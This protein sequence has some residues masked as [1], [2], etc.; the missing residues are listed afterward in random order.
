MKNTVV[1]LILISPLFSQS[2]LIKPKVQPLYDE[3]YEIE[4][5]NN[6]LGSASVSYSYNWDTSLEIDGNYNIK[7]V[8]N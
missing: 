5:W 1:I 3:F 4:R 2:D 8:V 7:V 6:A